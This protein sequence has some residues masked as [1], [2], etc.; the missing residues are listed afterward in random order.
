[1]L[2]V[3]GFIAPDWDRNLFTGEVICD[4]SSR[5]RRRVDGYDSPGR[6][7]PFHHR[8]VNDGL[9]LLRDRQHGLAHHASHF[10]ESD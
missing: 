7:H 9:R 8:F 1:M 3:S 6:T 5:R 2:T 10:L 4:R